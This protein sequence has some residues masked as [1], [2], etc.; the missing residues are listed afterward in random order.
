MVGSAV[1]MSVSVCKR[2]QELVLIHE[3]ITELLFPEYEEHW[4]S[5][6]RGEVSVEATLLRRWS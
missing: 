1:G 3:D 6:C 2:L 5:L 4:G